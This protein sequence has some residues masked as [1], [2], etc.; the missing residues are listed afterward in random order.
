MKWGYERKRV[1]DEES[2]TGYKIELIDHTR[3]E[4]DDKV[5]KNQG[6]KRKVQPMVGRY[7]TQALKH[8][9]SVSVG[10]F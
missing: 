2:R 10:Q 9:Q 1:R 5:W 4:Y 8:L 3:G 7:K 6:E